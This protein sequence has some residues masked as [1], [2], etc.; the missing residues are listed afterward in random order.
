MQ[1]KL[2]LSYLFSLLLIVLIGCDANTTTVSTLE[3]VNDPSS[4]PY[5]ERNA[6]GPKEE[7]GSWEQIP[8][9]KK[10][11]DRMQGVHTALL[12]SGKILMVNGSSNRNTLTSS[13]I[14][15]GSDLRNYT[16]I[17]NM[18]LFDPVSGAFTKLNVPQLPENTAETNDLF[19]SGQ[20]HL[21]N[22]NVL[23]AGGTQSYYPGENFRGSKAMRVF[24]WTK[25]DWITLPDG[26][27]GHWYPSVIPMEDGKVMVISGL[28]YAELGNVSTIVEFYDYTKSGK[29]AWSSVNIG[30][31]ANNPYATKID[32]PTGKIVDGLQMYPRIY[33][34]PDGRFLLT[35]DGAAWGGNGGNQTKKTYFM[36]IAFNEADE[37][38]IKFNYGPDRKDVNKV[39]GT[40][41]ADPTNGDIL[42]FAGQRGDASVN[43]NDFGPGPWTRKGVEVTR[44]ME[45]YR[46]PTTEHPDGEWEHVEEFLGDSPEDGRIMHLA[47]VLPTKQILIL[48]GGN[49]A[50]HRPLYYPILLTENENAPGGYSL[51]QM[52]QALQPRLYHNVS[53]LLPDGRV[54]SAGGNAARAAFNPNQPDSV[55]LN[56]YKDPEGTY[57][58]FHHG[59]FGIPAEIWQ[60]EIFSP[61]YLFI[62]GPTPEIQVPNLAKN[63]QDMPVIEYGK[64]YTIIVNDAT[65]RGSLV[66]IK[67]GAVTHAW[68]AGQRLIDLEITQT[69]NNRISFKAPIKNHVNAPAYYMMF[70]V[71]EKGK[72]SKA[73]MIQL[74]EG[75]ADVTNAK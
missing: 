71:N 54:L 47:T 35:H 40:A 19:C 25:E 17:N 34:I 67:L 26:A 49:Y 8:L 18:C 66:L 51:K 48:N 70:Y 12:P 33:A 75:K 39:Y 68:D 43:S 45:R 7:M 55:L 60:T 10:K 41:A 38:S 72:P 22:G 74:R 23:F 36:D 9:A 56:V 63:E 52:N 61:P 31:I 53:L 6:T 50:Y 2:N 32:G 62:E 58:E 16:A 59:Q 3:T 44:T 64:D 27:D 4:S 1:T 11:E 29:E 15:D 69:V 20:N 5:Y 42:L 28:D 65:K 30:R 24:D 73:Q 46:L 21:P 57:Q 37:P 14:Q 13:G